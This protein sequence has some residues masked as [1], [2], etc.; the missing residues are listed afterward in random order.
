MVQLN[1]NICCL[2]RWV[3]RIQTQMCLNLCANLKEIHLF[4]D[5]NGCLKHIRCAVYPCRPTGQ[6]WLERQLQQKCLTV[7]WPQGDTR[8]EHESF[9]PL[10][11]KIRQINQSPLGCFVFKTIYKTTQA[12]LSLCMHLCWMCIAGRPEKRPPACRPSFHRWTFEL[13]IRHLGSH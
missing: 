7:N 2:Q 1:E 13:Q 8:C 11:E 3:V 4:Y 9:A 12:R 5:W 10:Q 6:W